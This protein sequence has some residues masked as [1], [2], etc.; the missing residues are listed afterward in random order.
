MSDRLFYLME[1]YDCDID[2]AFEY[3]ERET[4]ITI[5]LVNIINPYG[6][7]AH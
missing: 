7:V 4:N 1:K 2:E 3:L 6:K 5:L